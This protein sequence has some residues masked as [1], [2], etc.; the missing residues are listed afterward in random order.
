MSSITT[1][2]LQSAGSA[3]SS[4]GAGAQRI[5]V[6]EMKK[7]ALLSCK[8]DT[9]FAFPDWKKPPGSNLTRDTSAYFPHSEPAESDRARAEKQCGKMLVLQS[10]PVIRIVR[11][12]A[13]PPTSRST[14][15]WDQSAMS[16]G[17]PSEDVFVVFAGQHVMAVMYEIHYGSTSARTQVLS[18]PRMR[19]MTQ[20]K[21]GED[22]LTS[23]TPVTRQ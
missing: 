12:F 8:V 14:R 23:G 15:S 13:Y 5:N 1:D 22:Q 9:V 4:L 10:S 17:K 19:T 7:R 21:N 20:S 3:C 6:E 2:W 11:V 18:P 16:C